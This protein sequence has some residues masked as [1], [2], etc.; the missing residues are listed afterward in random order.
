[1]AKKK[2]KTMGPE[3]RRISRTYTRKSILEAVEGENAS[4]LSDGEEDDEAVVQGGKKTAALDTKAKAEM[5]R[6]RAKFNEVDDYTLDFED[7]TGSSSQ[8][9]DAR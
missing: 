1:M 2:D 9:L 7:M 8:M 6:L 3:G 5:E 4:D